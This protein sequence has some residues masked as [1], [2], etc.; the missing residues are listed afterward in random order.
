MLSIDV[1]DPDISKDFKSGFIGAMAKQYPRDNG[2]SRTIIS[3]K[4]LKDVFEI[5]PLNVQST[6]RHQ[7]QS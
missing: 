4:L 7:F 6:C 2:I 1:E 3:K 5:F